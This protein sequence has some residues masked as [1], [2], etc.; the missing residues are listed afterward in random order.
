VV[1]ELRDVRDFLALHP[2]F[3][4]LPAA[5]LDD[6]PRRVSIRY[7]RRGTAFP[8]D[9]VDPSSFYL[10]RK[11]AVELRDESLTL[12]E[13]PAEGDTFDDDTSTLAPGL[14]CQRRDRRGYAG[15]CAGG[16]GARRT[17]P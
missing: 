12:V 15:V 14:R 9:R 1:S 6:L 3:A 11:G 8:P 17:A 5:T 4:S 7:L 2:P 16:I 10:L 13:K